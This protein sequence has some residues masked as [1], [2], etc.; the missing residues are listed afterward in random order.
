MYDCLRI[1]DNIVYLD[2]KVTPGAS[3]S[4]L[5]AVQ[6]GRLRVKIAAVP[7]NGKANSMLCAFMS[8]LLD[9]P[10]K[11]ISLH[12]GAASRFKTLTFPLCH[13]HLVENLLDTV[14]R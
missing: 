9:C 11:D 1:V 7:E 2:L 5:I 6:N 10:K 13:Q 3:R 4:Q 14:S 8:R 12:S